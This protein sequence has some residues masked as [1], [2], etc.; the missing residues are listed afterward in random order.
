MT[1]QNERIAQRLSDFSRRRFVKGVGVTGVSGLAGCASNQEDS[2]NSTEGSGDDTEGSSDS[3][4]PDTSEVLDQTFKTWEWLNPAEK[5]TWSPYVLSG[6][7]KIDSNVGRLMFEKLA[8]YNRETQEFKPWVAKDWTINEDSAILKLDQGFKWSNGDPYSADDLLVEYQMNKYVWYDA[9]WENHPYI[10]SVE[11]VASD[12]FRFNLSRPVNPDVFTL[13]EITRRVGVK[14]STYREHLKKFQDASTDEEIKEIQGQITGAGDSQGLIVENPPALGPWKLKAKKESE[15]D[16][17]RNE[18]YKYA[19]NINFANA[20]TVFYGSDQKKWQAIRTGEIDGSAELAIPS[21]VK[22]TFP[23]WVKESTQPC[24]CGLTLM[25][26]FGNDLYAN[27]NVREAFAWLLNRE[28][29]RQNQGPD[30][31]TLIE[32]PSG[33]KQDAISGYEEGYLG[34]LAS[35][36]ETY[37]PKSRETEKAAELLKAEG[38]TQENGE[39]YKPDGER[40]S[41]KVKTA[42][43]NFWATFAQ[44]VVTQMNEFG[45][46]AQ[47]V[48]IDNN[49]YWGTTFA[50]GD[51]NLAVNWSGGWNPHPWFTFNNDFISEWQHPGQNYPGPVDSENE[52]TVSIPPVGKRDESEQTFDL[53]ELTEGIQ[54][55]Q[56]DKEE[57]ELIR[58]V[59]W[60]YNY[61]L[62]K[63]PITVKS[64]QM[65]INTKDWWYADNDDSSWDY[66]INT[67]PSFHLP[68]QGKMR[69]KSGK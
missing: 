52:Y 61:D 55:A 67:A 24:W 58:K 36:F 48:T 26:Q 47:A 43:Q 21:T 40:W 46:D 2:E 54:T 35:Q 27:R 51:Y 13:N 64:Q 69:A 44:A 25:F 37:A 9:D 42:T 49:T 30:T 1:N 18:H 19:D 3:D 5:N 68:R 62:P 65:W 56:S 38:F 22:E 60:V 45:I 4:G 17:E 41:V 7:I 34:D 50:N 14:A 63:I 57:Q 53:Q 31:H 66:G 33:L 28:E 23:D 16:L 12:E 32:V 15:Y 11:K 6:S 59:A 8:L 39:W 10:E 20:K 29:I